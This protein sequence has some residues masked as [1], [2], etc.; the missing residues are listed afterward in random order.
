M[1]RIKKV[2]PEKAVGPRGFSRW[3]TPKMA[4]YYMGCCDCGLVHEM[5]F[6]AL[7]IVKEYKDGRYIAKR[8]PRTKFR[9]RLR[10]R[11]AEKYTKAQ[12]GKR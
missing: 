2:R 12:R 3:V 6:T 4:R 1:S 11:R 7:E 9:V 10:A 8:L 5:Q